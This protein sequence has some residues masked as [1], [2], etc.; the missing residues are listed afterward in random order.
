M[1]PIVIVLYITFIRLTYNWKFVSFD[2]FYPLSLLPHL[3]QLPICFVSLSSVLEDPKFTNVNRFRFVF[4]TNSSHGQNDD[5]IYY[6]NHLSL[7]TLSA[8]FPN[9]HL[10]RI[11]SPNTTICRYLIYENT[12]ENLCMKRKIGASVHS[13]GICSPTLLETIVGG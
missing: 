9:A 8:D 5:N 7:K 13:Y 4:L 6:L 3:W 11:I 2:H 12:L 10:C 1:L